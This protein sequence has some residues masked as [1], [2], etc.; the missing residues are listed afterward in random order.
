MF[1]VV[2]CIK[3]HDVIQKNYNVDRT[4]VKE[5]AEK[6]FKTTSGSALAS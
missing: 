5:T 3:S 4:E 1:D 2:Y 6:S